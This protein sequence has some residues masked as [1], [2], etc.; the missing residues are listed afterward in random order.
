[1]AGAQTSSGGVRDLRHKQTGEKLFK[2]YGD[3]P[4]PNNFGTLLMAKMAI[5]GGQFE[6]F[7]PPVAAAPDP[8]EAGKPVAQRK[9][10]QPVRSAGGGQVKRA[11]A[12]GAKAA[13]AKSVLSNNPS[14]DKLG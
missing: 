11:R 3:R 13:R 10:N 5:N 14:D 4:V 1:M 9:F 6:D 2:Q 8:S 7:K 12:S